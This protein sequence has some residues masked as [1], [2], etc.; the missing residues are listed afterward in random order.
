MKKVLIVAGVVLALLIFAAVALP[1]FVDLNDYKDQY[2]PL[3]EQ[4]LNRKVTLKEIRLTVWPQIGAR[5]DDF[6]VLEDQAFGTGAF[7]SLSALDVG[8]KL[9]PLLKGKVEVEAI[10]LR[11]PVIHVIKNREGVLNLST[12]GPQASPA[13]EKTRP[14]P[15]TQPVDSPLQVLALL[16]VEHLAVVDGHLSYRDESTPKPTDYVIENFGLRLDG[17]HLGQ[18]PRIH[19]AA[20]LHPWELPVTLEGTAGPLVETLEVER[21][22]FGVTVGQALINLEGQATGGTLEATLTAPEIN[23]A[24]LPV[25][26]P[27]TKPV[28]I[29]DLR[30]VAKAPLPLPEGVPIEQA[31][32]I[33]DLSLSV[34][35]GHSAVT[36]NGKMA[37]GDASL[38]A[39]SSSLCI[40]DLPLSLPLTLTKP[41]VV[42]NLRVAAEAHLPLKP[43]VPIERAVTV[44]DLVLVIT[45]GQ[46][47][48]NVKGRMAGGRADVTATAATIRSEDV[49]VVLPIE[50]PFQVK[51]V[52]LVAAAT[53]PL[54]QDQPIEKAVA[55][56]DLQATVLL[57]KSTVK[58]SGNLVNGL[59]R[60]RANAPTIWTEDL[61][62]TLPLTKPVQIKGLQVVAKVPYPLKTGAPPLELAEVTDLT[63]AINLGKSLVA[64]KGQVLGGKAVVQVTSS[65]LDTAELPVDVPLNTPVRLRGLRL[66]AELKGTDARVPSVSFQ[67]FEGRIQGQGAMTLGQESPPFTVKVV[68][69]NVQLG[70]VLEAVG[71]DKVWISGAATGDVDLQGLGFTM[72]ELTKALQGS[73]QLTL[74]DGKLEGINMLQEA[75]V[76]LKVAGLLQG[77]VKATVFS[78]IEAETAIKDGVVQVKT[79]VLDSRD[80]QGA[81]TGTVG[82]DHTLNL[83]ANLSLPEGLSGKVTG[84]SPIAN[85]VL[86]G[87]RLTVPLIITG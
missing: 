58:V 30:V 7:A 52:R 5:L 86:G 54:P 77:N 32:T 55:V 72:P 46:A 70:S 8:V 31:V 59:I 50:K 38:T 79:L 43:G 29:K 34:Q 62:L 19:M 2:L 73:V 12:L 40:E 67:L 68:L 37:G 75:M 42:K 23:T 35:A 33:S 84:A 16:A 15:T 53:L 39:S 48:V 57:G 20:T 45:A 49:P 76:L 21:F 81:A 80:F 9:F 27:L 87:K 13:P 65:D 69:Q 18:T 61:P 56:Q 17:V 82:L 1:F 47:A 14:A 4:A 10:T 11:D 78:K 6:T 64:V 66:E 22:K 51:D 85:F 63:L 83:R 24:A 25:T 71:T 26:L 74:K 41:V 60:A 36:L 3:V 28:A 44:S